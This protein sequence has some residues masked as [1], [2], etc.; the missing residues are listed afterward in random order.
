MRDT[1]RLFVLTGGPGSGKTTLID[2]LAA[3]GVATSPEVGRAII[4][5]QMAQGG[6]ALPW[7]DHLGFAQAML[8]GEVAAHAAARARGE[9][10]VLDRGVP[11]IVGFLRASALPVPIPI[12][13]AARRC[14]YNPCVFIAPFW[15]AIYVSDPER[16]QSADAAAATES[17]MIE[18]Y[19][20]YGYDL[21][22][23]P[24]API[25]NRV[26]FVRERIARATRSPSAR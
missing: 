25:A 24:R 13:A 19:R 18:T 10:V 16:R 21:I 26:A 15:D 3:Q 11:D 1:D 5:K 2:A 14:R 6:T 17:V 7:D 4:R 12:D 20:H 8:L 9:L 22:T 23:L